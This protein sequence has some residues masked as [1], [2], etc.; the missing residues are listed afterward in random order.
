MSS[1]NRSEGIEKVGTVVYDLSGID[2]TKIRRVVKN[3]VTYSK[4]PLTINIRLDDEVGHLV[5]RI[6][7]EGREVGK[8]GIDLDDSQSTP[9]VKFN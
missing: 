1:A 5:F 2:E 7:H 6:F 4:L 9:L 8:A 3:G